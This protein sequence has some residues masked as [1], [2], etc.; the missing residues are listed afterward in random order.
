MSVIESQSVV[1]FNWFFQ[2][3]VGDYDCSL[4]GTYDEFACC[5]WT[6][7]E[8]CCTYYDLF[9]LGVVICYLEGFYSIFFQ[10]SCVPEMSETI[11]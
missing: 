5:L 10:L 8:S 7:L 9:S 4:L 2:F 6:V 3:F 11:S 1:D